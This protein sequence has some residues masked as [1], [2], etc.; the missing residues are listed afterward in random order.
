MNAHWSL[1]VLIG[2]PIILASAVA[3][4]WLA[5]FA[6]AKRNTADE[7]D[8]GPWLV[9][10]IACFVAV[11]FLGLVV[12]LGYFPYSTQYHKWEP[13][14]GTVSAVSSRIL[15]DGTNI[16]QR[17]VILFTDGQE[18]SCDDTRCSL[19][20]VGDTLYLSCKRHWQWFS[21]PGYDCNYI[22]VVR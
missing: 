3:L 13:T 22:K 17:F 10:R 14:H 8:R 9:G 2:L 18:R 21:T 6:A 7:F 19:V 5:R 16:S 11:S 15:G 1:G 4:L 12:V 20:K